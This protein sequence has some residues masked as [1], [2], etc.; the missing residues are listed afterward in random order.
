[1]NPTP[2][3]LA[4][5]LPHLSFPVDYDFAELTYCIASIAYEVRLLSWESDRD[6]KAINEI[7]EL[8]TIGYNRI[9]YMKKGYD[10]VKDKVY[11]QAISGNNDY[12]PSLKHLLDSIIYLEEAFNE[13]REEFNL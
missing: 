12:R 3:Y 4:V 6:K 1:M 7:T 2:V 8:L 10:W 11:I 13:L 5:K 9:T